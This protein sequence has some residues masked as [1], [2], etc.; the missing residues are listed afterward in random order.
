MC[1]FTILLGISCVL[2]MNYQVGP[3]EKKAWRDRSRP[4]LS[5]VQDVKEILLFE[6]LESSF[7]SSQV[8]TEDPEKGFVIPNDGGDPDFYGVMFDAGS[9]GSRVHVFHFVAADG[10]P[11]TLLAELYNYTKVGLSKFAKKPE[12]GASSLKPLLDAALN[13]IPAEKWSS[14]PVALKATAGLRLLPE[15]E[16]DAL[17]EAV[18]QLFCDSPLHVEVKEKSITILEGNMEGI[19]IWFTLN[20]LLGVLGSSDKSTVGALDLG[21]GSTQITFVPNSP[22]TLREGEKLNYIDTFRF[23][24]KTFKVYTH[25]YLGLGL[26]EA[27]LQTMKLDH[28]IISKKLQPTT[29]KGNVFYS[30]CLP[31][32]T[33]HSWEFNGLTYTALSV[34]TDIGAV[35]DEC[36]SIT[37]RYINDMNVHS[38]P[39]VYSMKF[40]AMSYFWTRG[41]E[42]HLIVCNNVQE[43]PFLCMDMVFISTLLT[44]GYGFEH[45]AVLE[46]CPK[47][48]KF[49]VSW[50]LGA[51]IDLLH[52]HWDHLAKET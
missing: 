2:Y 30:S 25:S 32:N 1:F 17:L 43:K 38:P 19:Y 37:K 35:Y 47:I 29:S 18:Y 3:S 22:D 41:S 40:Y 49:E 34:S 33:T 13:F 45:D 8:S 12:E 42:V 44:K 36:R 52:T 5:R 21:G 51:T 20:F 9:T 11:P 27:R 46:I 15:E 23:L 16:A 50:A 4:G 6:N 26:K 10:S 28:N 14:S 48:G 39:E 24:H 7:S 31:P